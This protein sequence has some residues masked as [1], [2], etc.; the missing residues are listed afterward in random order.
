MTKDSIHPR[1]LLPLIASSSVIRKERLLKALI[2]SA[3]ANKISSGKIYEVLLQTYLFAGFP[4]ALNSL[5]IFN[6]VV[7]S[8]KSKYK[9]H[10]YSKLKRIGEKTCRKIY[11]DKY[12]KLISNTKL[13]SPELSDWLVT[14]GYGKVLSRGKLNLKEREL[15]IIT[16]LT[17]LGFKDQ[18]YSHINGAFRL[19]I[20][21]SEISELIE[22]LQLLG[23]KSFSVFGKQ[24]LQAFI[25]NKG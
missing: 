8:Y 22:A 1:F 18:L 7:P 12:E 20:K 19:G 14:E 21:I 6:E 15:A 4:A 11:G 5:K 13:F 9:K 10:S 25:K 17:V 24:V 3:K 23:S 2:Y 16:I